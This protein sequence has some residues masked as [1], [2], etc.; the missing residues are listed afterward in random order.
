MI[1]DHGDMESVYETFID[2]VIDPNR[3]NVARMYNYFLGGKD[4]FPSDRRA[5]E[6]VISKVPHVR[7]MAKHNRYFL[8]RCIR[9]LAEECQI[10]Q[11]LDFGTGIPTHGS[12][13]EVAQEI[14]PNARIVYVDNDPVVLA[15]SRAL[16]VP[17]EN[18]AVVEAD[19][20]DPRSLL[21]SSDVKELIDFSEPIGVLFI[22]V[23]HF[24]TDDE[25]P[26]GI[27]DVFREAV[28]SGSHIAITHIEK[29]SETLQAARVYDRANAPGVPRSHYEVMNFLGGLQLV[30]P[31]LVSISEWRPEFDAPRQWLPFLAGV[32]RKP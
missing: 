23:L 16:R 20:R 6:E 5:A 19:I 30:Y 11:F 13:H 26:Y 14:I 17:T 2:S 27:I 15:H 18:V 12:V 10:R 32:G 22:A 24:I 1:K 25:D 28:P 7:E 31:G 3:P 21:R 8:H 9:Y 29:T 4:N